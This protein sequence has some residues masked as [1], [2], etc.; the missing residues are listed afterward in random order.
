MFKSK[1]KSQEFQKLGEKAAKAGLFGATQPLRRQLRLVGARFRES[2]KFQHSSVSSNDSDLALE[3]F[4]I[5]IEISIRSLARR[6]GL[7]N[8]SKN[9]KHLLHRLMRIGVITQEEFH[10]L[11]EIIAILYRMVPGAGVETSAYEWVVTE[12]P[13]I[14]AAIDERSAPPDLSVFG[15]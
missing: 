6:C 3:L 12:G 13:R 11:R 14:L 10:V 1:I 7:S 5:E 9:A 2:K 8:D 15:L 4:R